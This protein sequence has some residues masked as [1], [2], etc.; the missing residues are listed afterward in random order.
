MQAE[1]ADGERAVKTRRMSEKIRG[2]MFREGKWKRGEETEEEGEREKG[3]GEEESG[4][5]TS[6]RCL[7]R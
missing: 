6:N 3:E 2:C 4:C 1:E 5:K 7:R